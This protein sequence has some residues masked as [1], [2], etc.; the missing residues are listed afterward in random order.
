MISVLSYQNKAISGV[1]SC[2]ALRRRRNF[3]NLMQLLLM[4]ESML[5]E[6]NTPQRAMDLR[7]FSSWRELYP[8]QEEA[9]DNGAGALANMKVTVL[10]RQNASWQ[11]SVVWIER[12]MEAHFR[13][14]LELIMLFDSALGG[15]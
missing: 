5:D 12:Q 6:L 10:F 14:A 2:P 1:I 15:K 11:G 3:D 7:T 4:I 8:A 9:A 13:S